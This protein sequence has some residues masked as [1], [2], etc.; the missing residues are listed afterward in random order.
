MITQE[1]YEQKRNDRYQR[2]LRA[3]EK[4]ERESEALVA[5]AQR[6][7]E[8]IPLGQPILV[9]H[10]SEK[11][12]RAYRRRIDDKYHKGY[13]LAQKAE[14]LRS[15]AT[16]VARNSAIFSDDPDAVAKI[17]GKV[18][19]LK[20][21]QEMMVA[22]N[23]LVRRGD[24]EGLAKLGYT[25]AA[26]ARLMTPDELGRLGFAP[27]E[28]TN[29][30]AN[31]RRLEK[32]AEQVAYQQALEDEDIELPALGLL[33]ELRPGENRIRLD[34]GKRVPL[35]TFRKLKANGWRACPSLGDGVFS[36]YYNNSTLY[37]VQQLKAAEDRAE[38]DLI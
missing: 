9:G 4:A 18:E 11:R 21:R 33:I 14:E 27:Y 15:R 30:S 34:Y 2:L 16:S 1:E 7:G 5:G 37:Y 35:E 6:M 36:S 12:D 8:G 19:Q 26:I 20:A 25:D 17:G 31:I 32:R 23:K 28:L 3:A 10:H 13:E 29:N 38:R 22:A 24:R